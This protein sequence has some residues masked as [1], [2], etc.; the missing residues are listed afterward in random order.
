[1]GY[2]ISNLGIK[3]IKAL[4]QVTRPLNAFSAGIATFIGGM[5][6]GLEF[7]IIIAVIATILGTGAGNSVN[8]FFDASIDAINNPE[9][10]IPSGRLSKRQVAFFSMILFSLAVFITLFLSMLA[11][12]IGIVNLVLL[13][14]Y[15]SHLKGVPLIGNLAVGY[16]TGSTFLFGGVSVG[17]GEKTLILFLLAALVTVSREI[18]KDIEDIEGDKK[19]GTNTLPQIIGEKKSLYI[20]SFFMICGI[21][22]SPIPI[23]IGFNLLYL[24]FI[25]PT[26]ILGVI[27]L[28]YAINSPSKSQK[29]LKIAMIIAIIGFL[30]GSI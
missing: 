26:N 6:G 1:M 7:E 30:V 11:I 25:I 24:G 14:I 22:L 2:Y 5:I 10:P 4:F 18:I 29:L 28:F 17:G 12:I 3:K 16:L 19:Q 9:R 20:S 21:I 15:S 23:A 13:I 27:S 8:D